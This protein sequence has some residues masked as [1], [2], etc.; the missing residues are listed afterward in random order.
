MAMVSHM[1]TSDARPTRIGH[2]ETLADATTYGPV[3]NEPLASRNESGGTEDLGLCPPAVRARLR[4]NIGGYGLRCS[5]G[6]RTR[7]SCGT[8]RQ[9]PTPDVVI[10]RHSKAMRQIS[11]AETDLR[12]ER[13]VFPCT[14]SVGMV[15]TKV[16]RDAKLVSSFVNL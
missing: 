13:L 9:I 15:Y 11:A 16:A 5:R 12:Q 8:S 10:R 1:S 3:P 2:I 6:P 14:R 4:G 7:I